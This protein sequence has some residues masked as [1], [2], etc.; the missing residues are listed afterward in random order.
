MEVP[1][2]EITQGQKKDAIKLLSILHDWQ[3]NHVMTSRGDIDAEVHI[4]CLYNMLFNTCHLKGAFSRR[5]AHKSYN[6]CSPTNS[7][8]QF[9]LTSSCGSGQNSSIGGHFQ[10]LVVWLAP[11][12]PVSPLHVFRFAAFFFFWVHRHALLTSRQSACS[13]VE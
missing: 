8:M 11:F 12:T 4:T 7:C 6:N 1:L 13:P 2:F 5:E 9:Q 3:L 10:C